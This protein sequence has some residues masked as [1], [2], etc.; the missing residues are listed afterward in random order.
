[1]RKGIV[2][3][4]IFLHCLSAFATDEVLSQQIET[5]IQ[6][7]DRT[8]F[9]LDI[10]FA[11]LKQ[12]ISCLQKNNITHMNREQVRLNDP[13]CYG[14]LVKLVESSAKNYHQMRIAKSLISTPIGLF[15]S[16]GWREVVDIPTALIIPKSITFDVYMKDLDR[17]DE[18]QD[19]DSPLTETES[20][21][22]FSQFTVFFENVCSKMHIEPVWSHIAQSKAIQSASRDRVLSTEAFCRL[23]GKK[24]LKTITRSLNGELLLRQ[25]T[26]EIIRR[27]ELE[28]RVNQRT[29]YERLLSMRPYL[30]LIREP[31]TFKQDLKSALEYALRAA[32][33]ARARLLQ[34]LA[35]RKIEI[36]V[37]RFKTGQLPDSE[38]KSLF[39]DLQMFFDFKAISTYFI[40]NKDL[41][42]P[43]IYQD[44][45]DAH[46]TNEMHASI[47]KS[48]GVLTIMALCFFIPE[49]KAMQAGL[50]SGAKLLA[51]QVR[52]VMGSKE[53]SALCSAT[54]LTPLQISITIH[55]IHSA[56]K[57]HDLFFASANG[58]ALFAYYRQLSAAHR[59]MLLN[60]LL[61]TPFDFYFTSRMFKELPY[62]SQSLKNAI[63]NLLRS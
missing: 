37:S 62:L 55:D 59:N 1:M 6:L 33:Q 17:D 36:R 9:F 20:Q 21:E 16:I 12:N 57:L 25:L 31:K 10:N 27:Y 28:F 56:R 44:L 61:F 38:M 54:I 41:K 22:A 15:K 49:G 40:L 2:Q 51:S 58:E 11:F 53:F 52:N 8:E 3:I 29:E 60:V 42:Y 50:Q 19:F 18:R 13:S 23:V 39:N 46:K 4:L 45:L 7:K 24:D 30:S 14:T 5:M 35:N 43:S 26:Q 47:A 34:D 63:W 48:A 32:N